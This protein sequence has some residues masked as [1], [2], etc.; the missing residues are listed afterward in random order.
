MLGI[1][2]VSKG[3]RT[4]SWVEDI[5]GEKFLSSYFYEIETAMCDFFSS[6]ML[7]SPVEV[8]HSDNSQIFQL[9]SS[10]VDDVYWHV[11]GGAILENSDYSINVL[12]FPD[13]SNHSVT[14]CGK[15]KSGLTFRHQW[16]L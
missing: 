8:R 5:N 13:T 14:V 3:V 1:Q 4:E 7:P 11:D 6:S 15:Y 12:L 2:G 10:D 9:I 16:K